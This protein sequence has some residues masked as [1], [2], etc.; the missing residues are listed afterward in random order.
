MLPLKGQLRAI[1]HNLKMETLLNAETSSITDLRSRILK[2]P[3]PEIIEKM[4]RNELENLQ[5]LLEALVFD[6]DRSSNP[7]SEERALRDISKK[8]IPPY[9]KP[10]LAT[11]FYFKCPSC[12]RKYVNG[13]WISS[14]DNN[15]NENVVDKYC[16]SC[17]NKKSFRNWYNI[18]KESKMDE[19]DIFEK[20]NQYQCEIMEE[21]LN[22]NRQPGS[23]MSWDV[24]PFARLKK[25]WEDYVKYG[26]VRDE[27]GIDEISDQMLTNLAK[28]QAATD[29]AGHSQVSMEEVA[30]N[31]NIVNPPDE[32]N[33]DFYFNFLDTQYG[34][35]IS[36]YGI[37]P[38]WNLAFKIT[39]SKTAEDK[40]L[41]IDQMLNVVHQRGDLAALFIEG[42]SGS[43]STLSGEN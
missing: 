29:L 37:E 2:L 13:Q 15:D 26:V 23:M 32:K 34:A 6:V 1:I 8:G 11:K 33:T 22:K 12:K 43:L 38:L 36:D 3:N 30:E 41:L 31:C 7:R 4:E 21:Y 5:Q 24:I 16:P 17:K 18:Y 14:G 35:P 40:L 39:K 25:I 20:V 19:Y 28:I 10:L 9:R 42:G 27:R